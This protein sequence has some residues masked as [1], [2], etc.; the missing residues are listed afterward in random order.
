MSRL[1]TWFVKLR[2]K[3]KAIS[4]QDIKTYQNRSLFNILEITIFLPTQCEIKNCT[5]ITDMA[6]LTKLYSIIYTD[7]QLFKTLF[8]ALIPKPRWVMN[9]L[10]VTS[11]V[12]K[13][14][15]EPA[16]QWE[17]CWHCLLPEAVRA[18]AK[19][20]ASGPCPDMKHSS[21]GFSLLI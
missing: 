11:M 15:W 19:V 6:I 14:L 12:V 9:I 1:P 4:V 10:S 20:T 16:W 17:Q 2:E 7:L 8:Q 13:I 18:G 3:K 5:S 21:L